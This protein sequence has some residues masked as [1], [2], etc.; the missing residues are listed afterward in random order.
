MRTFSSAL[1]A[2]IAL[3]VAAFSGNASAQEVGVYVGPAPGVYVYDDPYDGPA[4]L[5]Y[6]YGPR[7]YGYA[8][9]PVRDDDDVTVVYR[10]GGC[11]TYRY[12]NGRR[13]VDA[14]YQRY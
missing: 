2:A 10:S 9:P 13:C 6:T 5:P 11:G 7:Y 14:R 3:G 1:A 8:P 12:W 4:Y